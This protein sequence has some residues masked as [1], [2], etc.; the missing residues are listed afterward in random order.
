MIIDEPLVIECDTGET[1]KVPVGP[2]VDDLVTVLEGLQKQ[3][4]SKKTIA[5]LKISENTEVTVDGYRGR[6]LEYT[7]TVREDCNAPGW[8]V[9]D[10][11]PYHRRRGSSTSMVFGW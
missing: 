9:N 11:Q 3:K 1:S 5:A 4:V 10:N 6:Y 7:A 2:G 8:L